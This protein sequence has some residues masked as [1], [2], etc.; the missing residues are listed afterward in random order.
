MLT[1]APDPKS[2]DVATQLIHLQTYKE[3]FA[4]EEVL[5]VLT[6]LIAKPL[7]NPDK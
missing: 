3:E 2:S 6:G 5:T 4:T 1:M 7:S